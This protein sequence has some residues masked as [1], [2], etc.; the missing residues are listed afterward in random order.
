M[1]LLVGNFCHFWLDL[2]VPVG[3]FSKAFCH[4][5]IS[6]LSK[7][8]KA[9]STDSLQIQHYRFYLNSPNGKSQY[10]RPDLMKEIEKHP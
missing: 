3:Y 4:P 5:S 10:F 6:V 2:Y 1:R 8:Q 7:Q 9:D